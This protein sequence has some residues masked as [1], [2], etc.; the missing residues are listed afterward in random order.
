MKSCPEGVMTKRMFGDLSK[1]AL[2]DQ[3]EFLSNALFRTIC[4]LLFVAFIFFPCNNIITCH[5]IYIGMY[6]YTKQQMKQSILRVF[7]YD[8]SGTMDFE[9]Y[10]LAINATNLNSPEDK[11]IWMFDVFDKDGGGTIS[12][13][14][15][16]D[17]IRLIVDNHL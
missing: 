7:D 4:L 16:K 2:G 6:R 5:I 1:S 9:E 14:E 8:N 15:I 11:L 13:D 12:C 3:A 10:M 17:L